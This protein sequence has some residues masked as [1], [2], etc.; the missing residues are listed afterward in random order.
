MDDDSYPHPLPIE[1]GVGGEVFLYFILL[2]YLRTPR[3]NEGKILSPANRMV[4]WRGR[5][6]SPKII[7]VHIESL[8][9]R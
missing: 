3:K 1:T 8:A 9:Q 2:I 6:S 7:I 4:G 5:C